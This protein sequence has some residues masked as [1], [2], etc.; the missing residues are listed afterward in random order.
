LSDD[1]VRQFTVE[2]CEVRR[3]AIVSDI[4]ANVGRAFAE[5]P[6]VESAVLF[7]G[8]FWADEAID[9]VHGALCYSVTRN[10][11]LA[12]YR[13]RAQQLSSQLFDSA[14]PV[15]E[16]LDEDLYAYDT[17]IEGALAEGHL[18][19]AWDFDRRHDFREK[20]VYLWKAARWDSNGDAIPLFAAFCEEGADQD[21]PTGVSH[22][23]YCIFRREGVGVTV[24]I[25]GVKV[26]PWME[27]VAPQVVDE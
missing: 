17:W 3:A 5:F 7:V 4:A 10:P 14:E 25:V 1:I 23:P 27:G 26:R 16:E 22:A 19:G 20:Y 13:A 12:Q 24:E 8:Q 2:D 15:S 11:D 6:G 9:A 21:Q 18:G